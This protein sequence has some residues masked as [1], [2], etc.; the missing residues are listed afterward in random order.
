MSFRVGD[1]VTPVS[2]ERI[3]AGCRGRVF[4]VRKVNPKNLR[5]DAADGGRGFN[6]PAA[7]LVAATEE[8]VKAGGAVSRPFVPREFFS[9]GEIVSLKRPWRDWTTETPLVVTGGRDKVNVTLVGGDKDR[10]LRV[11]SS[12]LVRRDRGWLVEALEA[13][14]WGA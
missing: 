10:Y 14:R 6:C 2:D 8:N 12:G 3:P 4:I 1:R 11:P 7:L 9:L 13:E 5:C